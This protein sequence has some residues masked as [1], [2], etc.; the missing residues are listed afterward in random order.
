MRS[1]LLP[2]AQQVKRFGFDLVEIAVEEP[3]LLD[4]DEIAATLQQTGLGVTVCAVLGPGRDLGSEQPRVRAS[5]TAYVRWCIDAAARLGSAI[6]C[7]PLYGS[8]GKARML[9][10]A[11]RRE[12]RRRV[13]EAL[14]RLGDYAGTRRVRLALE[15]INRYETDMVNCTSQALELLDEIASPHVGIHLDTYH[16]HIEEKDSAAAIR[17]AGDRLFHFHASENDRGVPG[18]GQVDWPGISQ[19]LEE[20]GYDGAVVIESFSPSVRSIAEAVRLWRPVAP[21]DEAF[22]M[23]GQPFLRRTL[24]G[25]PGRHEQAG[26]G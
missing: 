19:A 18:T 10:E 11:D 3:R 22:A 8:V 13:V 17:L 2:L 5:T 25:H 7:G 12:E 14:R 20:V 23:E 15:P 21:G 1:P 4:L 6:V 24:G 9:P 16:M 26:Q